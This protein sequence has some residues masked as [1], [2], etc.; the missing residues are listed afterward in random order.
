MAILDAAQITA[1]TTELTTAIS[2][3]IGLVIPLV[4]LSV[5][6]GLVFRFLPKR[7]L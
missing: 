7:R 3:N 1:L 6:L 2:D 4:G 5:A